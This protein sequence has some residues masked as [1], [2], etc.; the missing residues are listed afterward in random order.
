MFLVLFALIVFLFCLCVPGMVSLSL[1]ECGASKASAAYLS[2]FILNSGETTQFHQI[3][4][5]YGQDLTTRVLRC[6]GKEL[7]LPPYLILLSLFVVDSKVCLFF[8]IPFVLQ[9]EKHLD[10]VWILL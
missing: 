8:S 10:S 4:K 1:P 7:L 6:V 9:V 5:E 3:V 2:Y